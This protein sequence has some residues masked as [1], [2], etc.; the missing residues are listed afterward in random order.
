MGLLRQPTSATASGARPALAWQGQSGFTMI[1]L[2]VSIALLLV[3]IVA[4]AKLVPTA[5]QS[6]LRNRIDSTALIVAQRELEQI[7]AQSLNVESALGLGHYNFVDSD[8]ALVY[9][10]QV[11]VANIQRNGCPLLP[12][13]RIDFTQPAAACPAGYQRYVSW[14]WNR[15]TGDT[16]TIDLRWHVITWNVAGFPARKL[17]VIGGRAVGTT[18]V[19]SAPANL[20]L[21]VGR[22]GG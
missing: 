18:D 5:L 6:N 8:G 14:V 22:P 17:F 21:V 20:T 2:L 12:D 3:G 16:Q 10:G 9:L 7:A 19:V 1:E 11:S 13:G 4:V 15:T